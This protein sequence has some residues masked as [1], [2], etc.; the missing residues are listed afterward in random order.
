MD[1]ET[2][3]NKRFTYNQEIIKALCKKYGLT[4]FFIRQSLSGHRDSVTSD[5]IKLEYKEL[6]KSI[7]KVIN[8]FINGDSVKKQ[9]V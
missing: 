9:S 7:A 8:D 3:K 1:K 4:T 5:K 6:E 2:K